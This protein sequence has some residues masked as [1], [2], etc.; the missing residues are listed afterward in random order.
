[1]P[2]TRNP[3]PAEFRDQLVALARSGRGVESFARE[4]APHAFALY[5]WTKQVDI[6]DG[7]RCYGRNNSPAMTLQSQAHSTISDCQNAP[8]RYIKARR[9]T[10]GN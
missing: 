6:D 8:S 9:Q 5:S 1:M 3:Q 7:D 2:R 4:C 10:V